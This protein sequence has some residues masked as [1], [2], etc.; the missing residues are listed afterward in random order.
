MNHIFTFIFFTAY[1]PPMS[2]PMDSLCTVPSMYPLCTHMCF[3]RGLN[4]PVYP[5]V[6]ALYHRYSYIPHTYVPMYPPCT[7]Y[8]R[9]MYPP[10]IYRVCS[11]YIALC[12]PYVTFMCP[13]VP[14]TG[15][16]I[17]SGSAV[18]C[19]GEGA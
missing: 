8:V 4:A 2:L 7:L 17:P 5:C 10:C 15:V 1:V 3:P 11:F 18:R 6:S 12:T 13:F 14:V 16:G 19:V 9:P